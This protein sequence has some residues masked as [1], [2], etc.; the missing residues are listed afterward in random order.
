MTALTFLGMWAVIVVAY[1][2]MRLMYHHSDIKERAKEIN[3]YG[4]L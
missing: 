4:K 3:D 2:I 1:V